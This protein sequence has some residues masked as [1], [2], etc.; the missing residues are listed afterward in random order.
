[1]HTCIDINEKISSYPEK[2]K[3]CKFL[4]K[5]KHK[6]LVP[7]N[8]LPWTSKGDR[9]MAAKYT[10]SVLLQS[11]SIPNHSDGTVTSINVMM[12]SRN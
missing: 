7:A 11:V 6:L 10:S 3:S 12:L 4:K 1:M 9:L 8:K 2:L 5:V